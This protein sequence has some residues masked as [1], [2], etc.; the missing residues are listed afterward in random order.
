[1][2]KRTEFDQCRPTAGTGAIAVLPPKK[3]M[4]D[5]EAQPRL[6]QPEVQSLHSLVPQSAGIHP[7]SIEE[8]KPLADE[9]L[10]THIASDEALARLLQ[11]EENVSVYSLKHHLFSFLLSS[12]LSRVC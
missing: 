6:A 2:M 9:A 4:R 8:R 7:V 12:P 10:T 5:D 11:E 3:R 1:M